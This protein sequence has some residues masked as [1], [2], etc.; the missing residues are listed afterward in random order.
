MHCSC[1]RTR[2]SQAFFGA[3]LPLAVTVAVTAA[4]SNRSSSMLPAR[5]SFWLQLLGQW[6]S[7]LWARRTAARAT[8]RATG[9]GR[10]AEQLPRLG[11]G[12]RRG[13]APVPPA[14]GATRP[15][16][17]LHICSCAEVQLRSVL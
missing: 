16:R 12:S 13:S 1:I 15:L 11:W 14:T 10:R 17:R 9:A 5:A 2:K 3:Q 4:S 8:A 7:A 6:L